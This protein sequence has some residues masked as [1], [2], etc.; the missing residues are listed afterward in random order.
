MNIDM[1]ISHQK[2]K[3]MKK[4]LSVLLVFASVVAIADVDEKIAKSKEQK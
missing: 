4:I 1:S 2:N 3:I